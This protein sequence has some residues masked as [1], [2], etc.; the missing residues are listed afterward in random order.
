LSVENGVRP[1]RLSFALSSA[2][3]APG[4]FFRASGSSSAPPPTKLAAEKAFEI[5]AQHKVAI[6]HAGFTSAA[7]AIDRIDPWLSGEPDDVLAET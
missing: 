2:L 4:D 7:T 6:W 1:S 5:S 3:V